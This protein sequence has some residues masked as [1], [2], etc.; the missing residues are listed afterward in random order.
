MRELTYY[1][2]KQDIYEATEFVPLNTSSVDV[3][4]DDQIYFWAIKFR[5]NHISTMLVSMYDFSSLLQFQLNA[6][7]GC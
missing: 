3:A 4:T 6:V 1:L 2:L 5:I 7:S